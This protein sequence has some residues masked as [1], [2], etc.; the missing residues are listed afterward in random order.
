M[1]SL[2]ELETQ[3]MLLLLPVSALTKPASA[4][5]M[6]SQPAELRESKLRKIIKTGLLNRSID[7]S[8]C[9]FLENPEYFVRYCHL[10]A[11]KNGSWRPK[12]T[13]TWRSHETPASIYSPC[14]I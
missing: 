11:L 7:C 6:E 9:N 12:R 4:T 3:L 2:A 8:F 1:L 14:A 5:N 13:W 10:F